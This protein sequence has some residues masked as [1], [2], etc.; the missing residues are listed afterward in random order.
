MFI[1]SITKL[2]QQLPNLLFFFIVRYLFIARYTVFVC[3]AFSGFNFKGGEEKKHFIFYLYKYDF[4]YRVANCCAQD[5]IKINFIMTMNLI[6]FQFSLFQLIL[7]MN[8]V[9][10]SK[11]L[12]Q[13]DPTKNVA[14]ISR[15][16]INHVW[17]FLMIRISIMGRLLNKLM[18]QSST[19]WNQYCHEN[20]P[21]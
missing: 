14:F 5:W 9:K 18:T 8:S 11:Y 10:L 19:R 17:Y 6:S 15:K 20:K 7:I 21:L 12:K 13:C 2:Q 16:N 1:R 3:V 4:E